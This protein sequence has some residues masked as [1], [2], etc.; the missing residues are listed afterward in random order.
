[1][2]FEKIKMTRISDCCG[3]KVELDS[4][5]CSDCGEHCGVLELCE[6]CNGEGTVDVLDTSKSMEMRI[7]PPIKTIVCPQCDGEGYIEE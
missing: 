6:V 3:A 4:D 2:E 1:M 7:N 5:I